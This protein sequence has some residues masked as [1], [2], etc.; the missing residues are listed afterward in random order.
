MFATCICTLNKLHELCLRLLQ[1]QQFLGE[2]GLLGTPAVKPSVA[3]SKPLTM[4]SPSVK[5]TRKSLVPQVSI[6]RLLS[7]SPKYYNDREH[8]LSQLPHP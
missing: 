7:I 2:V 4:S 6:C 1:M 3:A 5:E 8:R